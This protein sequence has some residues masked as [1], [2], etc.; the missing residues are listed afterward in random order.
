M[1][2]IYLHRTRL[3]IGTCTEEQLTRHSHS[4]WA[5]AKIGLGFVIAFFRGGGVSVNYEIDQSRRTIRTRCVGN[6]TLADVIRHLRGLEQDADCPTRL[7]VL[8][9]L[10]EA[11]SLPEVQE[12][13][14]VRSQVDRIQ[15]R[16]RFGA[17]ARVAINDAFFG[18]P[19]MFEV[20]PSG[21]FEPPAYSGP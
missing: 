7:D 17:C 19:R 12:L 14:M 5:A 15:E 8:P 1:E 11:S 9:D 2:S 4:Q 3:C 6:A 20:M 13:R 10:T 21:A 18:M 16:A